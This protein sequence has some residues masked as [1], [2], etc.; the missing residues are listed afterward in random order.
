MSNKVYYSKL[1][2]IN[3][4][5]LYFQAKIY[6]KL[7]QDKIKPSQFLIDFIYN[8]IFSLYFPNYSKVK[9]DITFFDN[10]NKTFEVILLLNIIDSYKLLI[11]FENLT[12]LEKLIF[13]ISK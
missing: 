5:F 3:I 4:C 7:Y 1:L 13:D 10:P 2:L 11:Y 8:D 12:I 9:D 6:V